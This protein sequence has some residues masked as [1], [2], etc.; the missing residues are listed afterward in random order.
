M[1]A[2]VS[3]SEKLHHR[4]YKKYREEITEKCVYLFGDR[5]KYYDDNGDIVCLRKATR[6][7][8][9]IFLFQDGDIDINKL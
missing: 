5:W 2:E 9:R 6:E 3:I 8:C 7:E 1:K 4:I